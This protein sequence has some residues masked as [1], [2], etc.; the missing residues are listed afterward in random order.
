MDLDF[1]KSVA[2]ERKKKKKLPAGFTARAKNDN[3]VLLRQKDFLGY[4]DVP[5]KNGVVRRRKLTQKQRTTAEYMLKGLSRRQ[6]QIKAGYSLKQIEIRNSAKF[7]KT[8]MT[9][10]E[11]MEDKLKRQGL[12]ETYM[13]EKLGEWIDA[14]RTVSARSTGKKADEQTDDF[15]DVPDYDTQIKAF[16]RWEKIFNPVRDRKS[17]EG[18][19][20]QVTFTDWVNGDQTVKEEIKDITPD[21]P[22]LEGE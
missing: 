2:A 3:G 21:E 15:I 13:A 16:D 4:V 9:F 17:D 5:D 14:K 7:H 8:L 19:K 1:F 20:R 12:T 10:I 22:E 18:K 11:T 6:A